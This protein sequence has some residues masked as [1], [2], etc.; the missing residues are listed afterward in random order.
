MRGAQQFGDFW[1]STSAI[2]DFLESTER[3][4]RGSWTH[5]SCAPF[6]RVEGRGMGRG[7]R[8]QLPKHVNF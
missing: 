1:P 4:L 2:S 7:F 8:G 5:G 6:A 3:L